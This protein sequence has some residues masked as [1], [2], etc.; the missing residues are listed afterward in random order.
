VRPAIA[1][2]ALSGP[3]PDAAGRRAGRRVFLR[4]GVMAQTAHD[5]VTSQRFRSLVRTRWTVSIVLTA[6]LFVLY[7]GYI[8]II[9]YGKPI[10]A[11]RVDAHTT[12][13]IVFGMLTIVGAWLLT[14]VYVIW[15]NTRY[16]R[17]VDE[18]KKDLA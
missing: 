13:G 10:L 14:V 8:L 16:D 3:F 6:L 9:A 12:L 17:E 2:A 11:V 15:A 7:Y 5:I 1:P 18:I 4:G